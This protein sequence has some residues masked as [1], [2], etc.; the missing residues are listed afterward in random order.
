MPLHLSRG[1]LS[2]PPH[3]LLPQEEKALKNTHPIRNIQVKSGEITIAGTFVAPS[4]QSAK[5][6]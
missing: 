1:I 2:G 4:T 6:L 3:Y 5:F